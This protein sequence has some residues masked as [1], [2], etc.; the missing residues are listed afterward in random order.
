MTLYA[1][2]NTDLIDIVNGRNELSTGFIDNCAF[3]AISDTLDK[4][5]QILKDML[6]GPGGGLEWSR[7]H[8]LQFK[9]SKL[10]VMDLSHPNT[11]TNSSPLIITTMN[12]DGTQT[13]NTI[14]NI[15]T[16]KYL[17]VIFDSKLN[18]KAHTNRVTAKATRWSQQL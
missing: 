2:Y 8:N 14:T 12:Q 4:T 18:W 6:G 7:C 11:P 16:Y 13:T 9:I 5:H 10:V 17:G 3:V 15:K 1:Y